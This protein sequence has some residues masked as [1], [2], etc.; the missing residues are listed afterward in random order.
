MKWKFKKRWFNNFERHK[1]INFLTA[2]KV[3]CVTEYYIGTNILCYIF[4]IILKLWFKNCKKHKK[5][6]KIVNFLTADKVIWDTAYYILTII[7][8]L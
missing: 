5:D 1:K 8:L 6:K 2:E 3:I 7:L 4:Y